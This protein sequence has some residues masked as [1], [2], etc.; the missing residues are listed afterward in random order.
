M[1]G[2]MLMTLT[3][4]THYPVQIILM[5]LRMRRSPGQRSKSASSGH[6]QLVN[7][8]A[9]KADFNQNLC[10]YFPQQTDEVHMMI[11]SKVNVVSAPTLSSF[12]RR[13]KPFLFQQSYPDIII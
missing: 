11:G 12:R 3:A 1:N 7:S 10:K 13:I 6:G 4:I 5:A 9:P 8:L 2:V